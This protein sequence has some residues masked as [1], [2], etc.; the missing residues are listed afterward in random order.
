MGM[1]EMSIGG[2]LSFF[3]FFSFCAAAGAR[4]I[5]KS[6]AARRNRNDAWKMRAGR[7]IAKYFLIRVR[8]LWQKRIARRFGRGHG[9][10]PQPYL[11][12]EAPNRLTNRRYAP[13]TPSGSWRKK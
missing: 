1:F 9:S 11:P 2:V 12:R 6:A 10:P 5:K 13:G 4:Q 3:F 8:L 7:R